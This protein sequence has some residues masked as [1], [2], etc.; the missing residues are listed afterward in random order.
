M[1]TDLQAQ[2]DE[3]FNRALAQS[4]ARDPREYYRERL[5]ALRETDGDAYDRA[6]AYYRDTLIP[7]VASGEGDPLIAWRD[8]GRFIAELTAP[9]H[10]VEVDESG[11]AHPYNPPTALDRMVL[12]IPEA[13][14]QRA[15]LV[16]LPGAPSP[17][18]MA[19]YDLLV[20]GKQKLR[21]L[22]D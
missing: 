20:M 11:R 7:R 6:V 1:S 10:T 18:Q 22:E 17:A 8:Y 19:T 14:N 2:A 5:R 15:L 13:R 12:H 16:G 3:F 9:G 4:G 21:V